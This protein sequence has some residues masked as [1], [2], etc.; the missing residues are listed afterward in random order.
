M[1]LILL[2]AAVVVIFFVLSAGRRSAKTDSA[3]RASPAAGSKR[4]TALPAR[5][6]PVTKS[7]DHPIPDGHQIF[8]QHGTIA[9]EQHR[10]EAVLAF[11]Q[12]GHQALALER[13]PDNPHDP[14]A[15][16]LIGKSGTESFFL[17][18]VP[19][20][21]AKQIV[22]TGLADEVKPRL[23]RIYV[24]ENGYT[25]I[26]FQLTGPKASKKAFDA[27]E[28]D[29]PAESQQKNYLKHFGLP[30]AKGLTVGAAQTTIDQHRAAADPT[31]VAEWDALNEILDEFDDRDTREVLGVKKVSKAVLE[32]ALATLTASGKTYRH[33]ADN[34]DEVVDA[35]LRIDP[36]LERR[37]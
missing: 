30:V 26:Q 37:D 16:R 22:T 12:A 7:F 9:G 17:G 11:T 2:T 23:R 10:K 34:M 4:S 8:V 20:D 36:K 19:K 14:N 13:E 27:Y 25:D 28:L 5:F 35:V 3:K 33:L 1:Y 31:E 18:Y 21:L 15:I 32:Q 6:C 24:A 29:L